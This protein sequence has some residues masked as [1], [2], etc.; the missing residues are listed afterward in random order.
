[1]SADE[2]YESDLRCQLG[3]ALDEIAPP[4]PP[5]MAIKRAGHAIR[6]R[7]RVTVVAALALA[8]AAAAAVPG[9]AHGRGWPR[10]SRRG[11]ISRPGSPWAGR[12][13]SR[14]RG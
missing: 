10:R 5:T 7:R 13:A 9:L 6:I 11:T 8:V 14:H 3:T 12:A 2:L 4:A 1:M